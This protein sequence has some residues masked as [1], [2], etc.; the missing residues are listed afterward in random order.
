MGTRKIPLR[1]HLTSKKGFVNT[2]SSPQAVVIRLRF[3]ARY[4]RGEVS[5]RDMHFCFRTNR[6]W[7]DYRRTWNQA[8]LDAHPYGSV[9]SRE[10]F[11]LLNG[12]LADG[13]PIEPVVD[14]L[15]DHFPEY[16]EDVMAYVEAANAT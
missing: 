3:F 13:G 2:T 8:D 6:V 1:R 16:R 10:G 9:E 11:K 14:W 12:V 5:L 15:C 7:L 4:R